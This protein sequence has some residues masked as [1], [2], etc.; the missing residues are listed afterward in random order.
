MTADTNNGA[1]DRISRFATRRKV[2]VLLLTLV[3]TTSF[4]VGMFRVQGS[5]LLEEL[6]PYEHPFLQIIFNFSEVFGT[7]GSW[8]GLL[9]EAQEGDIF[10][11]GTLE[12]ILQI[13]E[14][15]A[16][17]EET[18]R[19]LTF[20]VGSRSAQTAQVTGMGKSDSKR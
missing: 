5:V 12:K 13:D 6:L 20:S 4:G 7:G 15:V 10:K 9:V 17:W 2:L 3:L 18:F 16:T 11:P 8:V 1:L 19:A 14:E